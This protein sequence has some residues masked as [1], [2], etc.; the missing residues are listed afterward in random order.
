[1]HTLS[2]VT[3]RFVVPVLFAGAM[4]TSLAVP[5]PAVAASRLSHSELHRAITE[6]PT[7]RSGVVHW[8]LSLSLSHWGE[9]NWYDGTITISLFVPLADLYS[10]VVHEWSHELSVLDYGGNVRQAVAAM[11]EHFGGAGSTGIHGAEVAAD[12]MARL[13]GATWTYYTSC[14]R[15]AWRRAARRLVHGR[16]I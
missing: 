1:M 7:Y 3:G 12:C 13:Q 4:A 5:Q 8:R 16:R 10:V 2:R 14:H 9:T 15:T 11:N 6:V